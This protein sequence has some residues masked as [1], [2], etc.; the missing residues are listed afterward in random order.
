VTFFV[1]LSGDDAR[2]DHFPVK[3]VPLP[4]PLT[5]PGEHGVTA[6]AFGDVVD[7]LHDDDSLAD[8]RT[9]EGTD[10]TAFGEGAD[11]VDD[12]D[13]GLK[14]L[15]RRILIDEGRRGRWIA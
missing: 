7:E 11:Q 4:G 9:T 13:A 8:T 10:L 1:T 3:V 15:R 5:H 6:V 12:L 2:L 14:D